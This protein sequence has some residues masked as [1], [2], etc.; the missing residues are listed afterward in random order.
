MTYL[1]KDQIFQFAYLQTVD[2]DE[3]TLSPYD[4]AGFSKKTQELQTQ[5]AI[6]KTKLQELGLWDGEGEIPPQL[7]SPQGH[8]PM[9]DYFG[10]SGFDCL[11]IGNIPNL[12][13]F[14]S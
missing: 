3:L 8:K 14:S 6:L 7:S 12:F 5:M 11:R 10:Y 4:V 9:V 13:L 2:R 1:T